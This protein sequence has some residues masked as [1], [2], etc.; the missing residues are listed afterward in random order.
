M[1]ENKFCE[2]EIMFGWSDFSKN[3]FYRVIVWGFNHEFSDVF[4]ESKSKTSVKNVFCY[5]IQGLETELARKKNE[6]ETQVS[7]LFCDWK[8][9]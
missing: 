8:I 6:Y 3:L 4:W 5:N 9:I 1:Y 2:N 7:P